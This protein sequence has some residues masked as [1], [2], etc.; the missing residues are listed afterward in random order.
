MSQFQMELKMQLIEKNQTN[1]AKKP[2]P[3]T[4]DQP[5]SVIDRHFPSEV[6]RGLHEG[7]VN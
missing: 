2:K 5:S 3:V 4:K 7:N 1:R 6:P